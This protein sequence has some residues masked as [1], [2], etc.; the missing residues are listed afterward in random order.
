MSQETGSVYWADK[1]AEKLIAERGN[2]HITC[3]GVTPSGEIHF[4]NLKEVVLS[5]VVTRALIERGADARFTM[6][7]DTFDNLRKLYPFLPESFEEFVGRPISEIPDPF[8]DKESYAARFRDQFVDSLAEIG[9]TP[10]IVDADKQYKAG[11]Y[12]KSIDQALEKEE[13]AKTIITEVSGR[14]LPKNFSVYNPLCPECGTITAKE[15]TKV[16]IPSHKVE[17]RCKCGHEGV[18]DYSRGEGKLS[19]RLDWPARWRDLGVTFEPFGKDHA[20]PGGSRDTGVRLS[21]EIFCCEPPEPLIYEWIRLK[22]LGDMSSSKGITITLDRILKTVPPHLARYAILR[23]HPSKTLEF[24]P[25]EGLMRMVDQFHTMK[26][27]MNSGEAS[28]LDQRI[29]HFSWIDELA[30]SAELK[31]TFRHIVTLIQIAR[32]DLDKMKQ[33][34]ARGEYAS[35]LEEW[36]YL[37]QLTQKALAWLDAPYCPESFK[38]E[39]RDELPAEAVAALSETQRKA[40]GLLAERLSALPEDSDAET[41]HQAVYAVKDELEI[42]PKE[43]FQA[44]YAALLGKK[45]GPKA[46]WFIESLGLEFCVTRFREAGA[47]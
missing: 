7:F 14:D 20:T 25:A 22:G 40:L 2:T 17:Y 31:M 8:G 24:D 45:S 23:V 35:D 36:D 42:K 27:K 43:I 41:I 15:I 10:E 3:A 19:W 6:V 44:V 28:E 1:I 32:G 34:I 29:F 11:V 47:V 33:I 5:D 13:L 39:V 46:G 18:S 16:D 9:I 26:V 12:T 38:I 30:H 37:K 4:G 21:R